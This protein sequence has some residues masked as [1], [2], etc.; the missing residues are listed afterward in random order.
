M[1]KQEIAYIRNLGATEENLEYLRIKEQE[2]KILIDSA[3]YK[4]MYS[5]E[6]RQKLL[7]IEFQ[8]EILLWVIQ[9]TKERIAIKLLG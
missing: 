7:N 3:I 9:S 1:K 6:N 5:T 4:T 8:N 2:T